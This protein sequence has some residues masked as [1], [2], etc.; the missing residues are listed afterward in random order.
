MDAFSTTSK[1]FAQ[2]NAAA[3]IIKLKYLLP[4]F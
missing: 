2:N 1:L 3:F 4:W